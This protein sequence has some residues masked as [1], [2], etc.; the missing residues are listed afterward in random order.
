MKT[1]A[2][3]DLKE[4]TF[5]R[6]PRRARSPQ[7]GSGVSRDQT[8]LP[9]EPPTFPC[10]SRGLRGPELPR[11]LSSVPS[12]AINSRGRRTLKGGLFSPHCLHGLLGP[13]LPVNTDLFGV[14]MVLL[15]PEHPVVAIV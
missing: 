9:G 3:T 13:P 14:W 12:E 11:I 10:L 4:Q 8:P 15:F 7:R 5:I 2:D 6:A 1:T